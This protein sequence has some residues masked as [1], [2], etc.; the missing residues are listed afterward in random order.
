MAEPVP[1]RPHLNAIIICDQVYRESATGKFFILGIFDQIGA[2]QFPCIHPVMC[3]YVNFS[4]AQGPY[5]LRVEMVYLDE[6]QV[7]AEARSEDSVVVQDRLAAFEAIFAFQG[8]EFKK[9]GKYALRFFANE[10]F[11]GDK[12][13]YVHERGGSQ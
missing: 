7:V 5:K 2:R 10:D 1:P 9:P 11:L 6:E 3:L 8:A 13:F 4:D 12:T